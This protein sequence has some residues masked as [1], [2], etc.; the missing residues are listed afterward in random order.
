MEVLW[1]FRFPSA[2]W[3]RTNYTQFLF[4]PIWSYSESIVSSVHFWSFYFLCFLKFIII[5][6]S[7]QSFCFTLPSVLLILLTVGS[8]IVVAT[9]SL[10]TFWFFWT[11]QS[12]PHEGNIRYLHILNWPHV[13]QA[14][15]SI[16]H[17]SA[18]THPWKWHIPKKAQMQNRTDIKDTNQFQ[19]KL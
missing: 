16:K 11:R 2:I 12:C 1:F 19:P 5:T 13:T 17:Q 6:S 10:A 15:S 14:Y 18:E 3:K 4:W 9:L 7:T 8:L